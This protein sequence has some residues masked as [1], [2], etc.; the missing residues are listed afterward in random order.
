M[1]AY[2]VD[3]YRPVWII[4][5]GFT[6]YMYNRTSRTIFSGYIVL[7]EVSPLEEFLNVHDA[8]YPQAR[9]EERTDCVRRD[10]HATIYLTNLIRYPYSSTQRATER[11]L[12][13]IRRLVVH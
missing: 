7:A 5:Q 9:I 10:T 3:K 2:I 1:P 8:D 13:S 4:A 11:K 12:L 6:N